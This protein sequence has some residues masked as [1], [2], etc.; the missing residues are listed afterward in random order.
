MTDCI[1]NE[2][3]D[4]RPKGPETVCRLVNSLKNQNKWPK[5]GLNNIE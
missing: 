5:I 1:G 2:K 4:I 3:C